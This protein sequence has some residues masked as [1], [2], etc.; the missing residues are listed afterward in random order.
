M[1][2]TGGTAMEKNSKVDSKLTELQLNAI[3]AIGVTQGWRPSAL[4]ELA[5]GLYGAPLN[6]LSKDNAAD[7][8]GR[9]QLSVQPPVYLLGWSPSECQSII[10][11]EGDDGVLEV[12]R[13]AEHRLD[14]VEMIDARL[15]D[16]G[17]GRK[18]A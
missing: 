5:I 1:K 3:R 6:E 17:A 12:W 11:A 7:L 2:H 13:A 8:I 18:A 15:A 4:Q 9:L 16:L 14:V 10:A